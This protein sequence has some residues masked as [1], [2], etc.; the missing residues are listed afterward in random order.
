MERFFRDDRLYELFKRYAESIKEDGY[1]TCE[2][3]RD[4]RVDCKKHSDSS[5]SSASKTSSIEGHSVVVTNYN[6]LSSSVDDSENEEMFDEFEPIDSVSD[7]EDSS[8]YEESEEETKNAPAKKDSKRRQGPIDINKLSNEK[9]QELFC[10]EID[11]LLAV[12]EIIQHFKH[13]VPLAPPTT[14]KV[15]RASKAIKKK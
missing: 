15:S 5:D 3:R 6:R 13:E 14:Q 8:I 10:K 12:G 4:N 2:N 1:K 7:D 11:I 9:I